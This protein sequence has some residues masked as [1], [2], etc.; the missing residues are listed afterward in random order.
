M[1]KQDIKLNMYTKKTLED[2]SVFE[3]CGRTKQ[4]V[5]LGPE[6]PPAHSRWQQSLTYGPKHRPSHCSAHTVFVTAQEERRPHF[7]KSDPSFHTH[8]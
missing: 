3:C 2:T 1:G 8:S 5:S 6:Q 4:S 7:K